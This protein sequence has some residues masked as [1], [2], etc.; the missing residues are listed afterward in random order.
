MEW[1]KKMT[2]DSCRRA[3]RPLAVIAALTAWPLMPAGA[4]AQSWDD[5]VAAAK[6]EA[7]LTVYTGTSRPILD[8]EIAA[9]NAKYPEI[10]ITVL[11]GEAADLGARIDQEA[12]SGTPVADLYIA[13][14]SKWIL[15]ANNRGIVAPLTGPAAQAWP[16]EYRTK[17]SYKMALQAGGIVVNID[18]VK[19]AISGYA[20]LIGAEFANGQLGEKNWSNITSAPFHAYLEEHW[21]GL[22]EKLGA[23]KPTIYRSSEA[24]TSSVAAGELAAILW[25]APAV[26]KNLIAQGAPIAFVVPDPAFGMAILVN[27]FKSVPHSNA[28][29]LFADFL[30]SKDG[31][32]IWN[33]KGTGQASPLGFGDVSPSSIVLLDPNAWSSDEIAKWKAIWQQ[34]YGGG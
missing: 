4:T 12:A 19:R 25:S 5:V 3:I 20:D 23:E 33:A 13:V 29:Q 21:P 6:T 18:L 24:G 26:P 9:F 28:A 2:P 30:L 34:R 16:A 7:A 1:E 11:E 32:Q 15:D 14:D 22:D 17:D 10:K 8:Q 31:Q 27:V